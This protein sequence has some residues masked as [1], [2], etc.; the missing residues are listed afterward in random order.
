MIFYIRINIFNGELKIITVKDFRLYITNFYK[1]FVNLE[2]E[3]VV[4]MFKHIIEDDT[5]YS[6]TIYKNQNASE[7][8]DYG[9]EF[10]VY[11][12]LCSKNA[13]YGDVPTFVQQYII[14][15]KLDLNSVE[16]KNNLLYKLKSMKYESNY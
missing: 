1:R 2:N 12:Y 9:D 14:D 3:R 11:H 5:F 16:V 7:I 13:K 8:I 4:N 10:T 15:N 6:L